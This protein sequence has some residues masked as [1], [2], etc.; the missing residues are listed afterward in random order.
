VLQGTSI[1]TASLLL[2]AE[3]L[4]RCLGSSGTALACKLSQ[5][6]CEWDYQ[7][8]DRSS[9]KSAHLYRYVSTILI[10]PVAAL[11]MRTTVQVMI[12]LLALNLKGYSCCFQILPASKHGVRHNPTLAS[13]FSEVFLHVSAQTNL[14]ELSYVW[15]DMQC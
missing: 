1:E 5:A 10:C 9:A 12:L 7:P 11:Y 6:Y 15:L 8:S 3:E 14:Q 4:S 2:L 13:N